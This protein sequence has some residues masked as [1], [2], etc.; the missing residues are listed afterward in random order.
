L[1]QGSRIWNDRQKLGIVLASGM[2]LRRKF[3]IG[4]FLVAVPVLVYLLRLHQASWMMT[5]LVL[6][7]I[8]PAFFTA[9]SGTLLEVAPKLRQDIIPLQK[10]QIGTNAGRLALLSLT[11]F[12]FPWAFVA[13]LAAGIPQIWA[14]IRLRRISSGYADWSQHRDSDIQKKIL[15]L[16]KRILPGAIYYSVSG[17]VT[18]WLISVF[19]ST[20][21]LAQLGAL[22]RLAMMLSLVNVLFATLATPRFARLADSRKILL[23][24]YLQIQVGLVLLSVCITGLVWMFPSESLWILGKNYEGLETELVLNI[25]G[26][27]LALIAGCSFSLYS[28]RG[29]TIHPGISVPVSLASIVVGIF[30]IDISSLRGIFLLNIFIASVQVVMHVSYSLY[31]ILK[32]SR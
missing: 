28:H 27:C 19:G 17:Q 13:V 14:N 18:I 12:L 3:A 29:W 20:T 26:S 32:T 8:I 31:R 7:S 25:A 6:L 21:A 2:D 5:V 23:S 4:S 1:A 15:H 11:L 24:R 16:V 9:L 30:L 22:G 10:I